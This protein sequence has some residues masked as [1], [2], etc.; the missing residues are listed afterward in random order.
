VAIV[1]APTS[2]GCA[3]TLLAAPLLVLVARVTAPLPRALDR[4][5]YVALL[6]LGLGGLVAST[7]VW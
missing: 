7:T 5:D 2:G 6:V 4:A 1:A 3:R